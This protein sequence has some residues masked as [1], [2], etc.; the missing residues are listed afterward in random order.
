MFGNPKLLL[1]ITL[2]SALIVGAIAALAIGKW[3]IILIPLAF[4]GIGTLLVLKGV[5]KVL[6]E[7]DKPDPVTQAHMDDRGETTATS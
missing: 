4:H 1:W 3:W 2:A 7:R 5:F 6:G